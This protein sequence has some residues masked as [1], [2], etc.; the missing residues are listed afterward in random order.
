MAKLPGRIVDA[1]HHLWNPVSRVPDIGYEWLAKIGAPKP[2][3]D[4]TPIQR[5]YLLDEFRAETGSDMLASVHVQ[6]DGA[7][8]DPVAET[9]FIQAISDQAGFPIA[10]VGFVDLAACNAEAVLRRHIESP[11][12][13]GVRQIIARLDHRPELS[14]APVHYLRLPEWRANFALLERYGLRFDL[15]LYPEQMLEA[16]AFLEEF[17]AV[18]VIIDHAGSPNDRSSEG[19]E[20][21]VNGIDA[22]ARLPNT[23]LK[24]SGFGMFDRDWRLSSI[25]PLLDH[26]DACFGEQRVLFGSNY[27]VDKLMRPYD[28]II[29]DLGARYQQKG[30]GTLAAVF[31]E[32][33]SRI[34]AIG[35]TDSERRETPAR[36]D[37][38][39]KPG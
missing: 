16:A 14:F 24:L 27:P 21:W 11:N 20:R 29:A 34:Y 19:I 18:P 2:F 25:G 7:I 10:I 12:F 36:S 32:N 35:R 26:I 6:A 37:N 1:H 17:P 5:D 4:P 28:D 15:Q 38:S 33:A 3:G 31:Y 8:P 22:L 9:R 23:S 30:D 13:R 39:P